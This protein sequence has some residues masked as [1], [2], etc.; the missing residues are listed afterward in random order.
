MFPCYFYSFVLWERAT[1]LSTVYMC[2]KHLDQFCAFEALLFPEQE[3]A[4]TTHLLA[5]C[6]GL[7]LKDWTLPYSKMLLE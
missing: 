1:D 6:P 5:E 4:S 2:I 7:L 3:A